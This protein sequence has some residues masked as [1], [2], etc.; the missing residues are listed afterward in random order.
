MASVPIGALSL[1]MLLLVEARTGQYAL[2]GLV[3]GA[4]ACG[5][6]IGIFGQGRLMD[7]FGQPAVLV[8]AV[9]VQLPTLCVFALALPA[10]SPPWALAVLAFIAGSCEPHVGG[11]SSKRHCFWGRCC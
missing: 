4:L 8:T 3:I 10:S 5:I 11:G 1:A 2:A 9:L 6:G 7:R